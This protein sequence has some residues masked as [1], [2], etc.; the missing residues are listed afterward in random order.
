MASNGSFIIL[1]KGNDRR[2]F[3]MFDDGSIRETTKGLGDLISYDE[4]K[5]IYNKLIN[6]GYKEEDKVKLKTF[7]DKY[8]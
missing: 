3:F 6:D 4:F 7:Y 1:K 2:R 5:K 8:R